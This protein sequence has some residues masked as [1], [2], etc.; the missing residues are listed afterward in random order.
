[1]I[2]ED[3]EKDEKKYY[4]IKCG[5]SGRVDQRLTSS[6][7]QTLSFPQKRKHR[8]NPAR[9]YTTTPSLTPMTKMGQVLRHVATQLGI[10]TDR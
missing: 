4:R 3:D 7:S 1:M 8:R 6:L 5:V 10:P 9:L 2:L